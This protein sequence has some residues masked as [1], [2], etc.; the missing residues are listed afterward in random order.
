MS[1]SRRAPSVVHVC[2]DFWPSTGGIQQFVRDLATRSVRAG[3]QVTVLCY[4]RAKGVDAILPAAETLEGVSIR[5]V[6]FADLTY[7]KPA[8][9]PLSVL[10]AHD[11]IHVH[12]V[13]APLDFVALTK[14]VHKRAIV[15]STHGGIFH[16]AALAPLKRIYFRQVVRRIMRHVD[17]VA[18]CSKS[19]ARLFSTITDRVVLIE[20]AVAIDRHLALPAEQKVPGRCLY[21]GRLADNKGLDSLLRAA[22]VA[23]RSGARLTLRLVGPDVDGKRSSLEALAQSLGIAADVAF[24]GEVGEEALLREYAGAETFVS[25]SRYEGFGLAAIEAKAAGCRLLLH[26]N[27][28]FRAMFESDAG[29]T[30]VDF[31]DEEIAGRTWAELVRF[32]MGADVRT[33]RSGVEVFSWESKISEW[34]ALYGSL[35]SGD[36][37]LPDCVGAPE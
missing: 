14:W 28:A 1:D 10:N 6:P 13:G 23:R 21:V 22:A 11:V 35:A 32:P 16:T 3:T 27:E 8:M 25:A 31:A 2:T 26:T 37:S 12:G 34:L 15:V 7:Y 18:A 30:L 5:R 24:L 20:N 17:V 19:D 9:L 33:A 29:A 4:N 36:R